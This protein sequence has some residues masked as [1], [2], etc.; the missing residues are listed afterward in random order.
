M[1]KTENWEPDIRRTMQILKQTQGNPQK[2]VDEAQK[3]MLKK[4]DKSPLSQ[5]AHLLSLG[6]I[7]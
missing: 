4:A 7:D 3:E 2:I 1:G 5:A 6:D